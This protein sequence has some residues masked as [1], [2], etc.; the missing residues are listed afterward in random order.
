MEDHGDDRDF[1][2]QQFAL[3]D[4]DGNGSIDFEE[5]KVRH[6]R[7]EPFPSGILS[8]RHVPFRNPNFRESRD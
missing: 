4:Q 2:A 7:P 3:H 6:L 8:E 1:I 5:F